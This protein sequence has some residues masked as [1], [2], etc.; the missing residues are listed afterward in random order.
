MT[1]LI[2][3]GVFLAIA[4][5]VFVFA[6]KGW[7][8]LMF[9]RLSAI[10]VLLQGLAELLRAFD[11]IDLTAFFPDAQWAAAAALFILVVNNYLREITTTPPRSGA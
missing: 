7:R 9:N 8:T 5:G 10:P 6:P 11:G 4:V 3:L 1:A 2:Y